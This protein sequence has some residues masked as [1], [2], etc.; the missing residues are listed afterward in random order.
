MYYII[1]VRVY[2]DFSTELPRTLND[3]TGTY[4]SVYIITYI[5]I[6][7]LSDTCPVW[8]LSSAHCKNISLEYCPIAKVSF[9]VD[10]DI[11]IHICDFNSIEVRAN[12]I[13]VYSQMTTLEVVD[14]NFR[15]ILLSCWS[16]QEILYVWHYSYFWSCR[17]V[18]SWEQK[19][20]CCSIIL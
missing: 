19:I 2:N 5:Y 4:G 14:V 1:A 13:A 10:F 12:I 8:Y 16:V 3:I 6:Y 9:R 7:V 11:F 15:G 17:V 20:K 18:C